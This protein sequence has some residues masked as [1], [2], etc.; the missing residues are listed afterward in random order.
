MANPKNNITDDHRRVHYN[1]PQ[2]LFYTVMAQISVLIWGRA[3]GKS[4]GPMAMFTVDNIFKMPRSSGFLLGTTYEQLLTRTL[5]PLIAGWEKLGFHQDIHYTIRKFI[6]GNVPRPYRSPQKADHF[7]HW[8]NGTGIYLVSQDRPGTM[9]GVRTQWGAGDEARLLNYSKVQEEVLPTMA[10]QADKFGHLSNYLSL[11]YCSDMPRTTKGK[12]LLDYHDQMDEQTIEIILALQV[13]IIRL[14]EQ[15]NNTTKIR[16]LKAIHSDLKGKEEALNTIRRGT[17]YYS[18]AS[19]LDNIHV[20]GVDVIKHFKRILTDLEFATSVLNKRILKNEN[21]FYA[22]LHEDVHGYDMVNYSHLDSLPLDYRSPEL[23]NCLW[24]GDIIRD[25]PLDIAMDF[26]H[27]INSIIT[28][29]LI[30]DYEARFLSSKYVLK[31]LL[32]KDCLDQWNEYYKYHRTREVNFYFDHTAKGKRA[33]THET[34][35]DQVVNHLRSLGWIVNAIDMGQ[36]PTHH[37]RFELWGT[38]FQNRDPRLPRFRFN[39][40]NSDQWLISCQQA[41]IIQRGDQTKKDKRPELDPKF[42]QEEAPHLSEAGDLLMWGWVKTK[43]KDG[44][45]FIDMMKA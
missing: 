43:L 4:E 11:L 14:K 15:I 20:L 37:F 10:G 17:V 23:K 18:L 5:P 41:G 8:F 25:Q 16:E 32:L 35:A 36:T 19:T 28:G 2:L 39:K 13:E 33:D 45:P 38:I 26:N 7:I 1:V 6:P 42:P 3:T 24:D 29:Q 22:L 44:Q 21:G 40:T 27:S 9:N 30:D 12:W 34:F 31:P